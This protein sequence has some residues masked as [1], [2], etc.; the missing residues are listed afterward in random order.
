[1]TENQLKKAYTR[2]CQTRGYEPSEG[3]FKTW[4]QTLMFFEAE[5]IERAID[6]WYQDNTSLP[7]PAEMKPQIERARRA[8]TSRV[9]NQPDFVAWQC[10]ACGMGRT[11]WPVDPDVPRYC[12]RPTGASQ[13]CGQRMLIVR[14]ESVQ[15]SA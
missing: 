9:Q 7:M 8:R 3:Q 5:D 15:V 2:A 11:G 4:K 14:R 1:M 6:F 12:Q 13:I 10:P